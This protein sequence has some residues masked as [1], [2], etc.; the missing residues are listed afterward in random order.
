MKVII[1]DFQDIFSILDENGLT[2]ESG[3]ETY[4]EAEEYAEQN[5]MQ[6]VNVFNL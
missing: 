3:F 1:E 4:E 2:I 5:N 6:I